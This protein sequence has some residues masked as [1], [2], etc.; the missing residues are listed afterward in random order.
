MFLLADPSSSKFTGSCR[1]IDADIS[2]KSQSDP[3]QERRL[4]RSWSGNMFQNFI[5]AAFV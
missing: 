4:A 2:V 5:R 1:I 3:G